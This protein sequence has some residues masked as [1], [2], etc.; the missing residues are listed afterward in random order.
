M[1]RYPYP[2]QIEVRHEKA[3]DDPGSFDVIQAQSDMATLGVSEG[4]RKE[5][6]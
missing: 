1:E 5:E 2:A 6:K 4:I 3:H